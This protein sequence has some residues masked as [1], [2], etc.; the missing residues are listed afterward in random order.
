MSKFEIYS[1]ILCIIVFIML[2]GV[3]SYL[4]TFIVKLGLKHIRAGLDDEDILKEFNSDCTVKQSRFSKVFNGIVNFTLC[5]VI[6]AIFLSSF[7]IAC[8][9][10]VYTENVPTYRVVL[11]SSMENKN[12]E[13]EYLFEN[14]LN[15][16]L[17][18]F[19]LITT[20]KI[21]KEE[22][23]K[24]YDIVV[25][26]VDGVLIVHRIVGI[27]E[28]NQYHP[29]E[30]H[31]LLQGDAVGSPD[32]F[33]VLY[34]QMKGIYKGQKIPFVG[35][36]ILFMQSPAGWICLFLIIV[37]IIVTP[38]LEKK[39]LN[40]R[41]KRFLLVY[42]QSQVLVSEKF[43]EE[44]SITENVDNV[45]ASTQN[46]TNNAYI[47]EEIIEFNDSRFSN[48]KPSKTFI[49]K[50][51][52]SSEQ[53]KNRYAQIIKTL[54]RIENVRVIEGKSQ[55]S[56]K[57]KSICIARLLFKG[58]TLNV[59]LGLNPK[60]YE[61]SKYVFTDLSSKVKHK[62]YPTCLK[63]TSDRQTRWACELIL[64]LANDKGLKILEVPTTP[65]KQ[66]SPFAHLKSKRKT[67]KQK[68]KLSPI[69]K[70]R[71]NNLKTYLEKIKGIK[72][73]EGKYQTTFKVKN[74]SLIK[75]AIKGKMLNAYLGLSPIDYENSKYI[76]TDVSKIKKFAN[77]P[78][79]VKVSSDRQQRWVK[80][81]LVDKINKEGLTIIE[82]PIII[83]NKPNFARL[84]RKKT[85]SFKQKLK[86]SPIAK[87]RFIEIKKAFNDIP[88]VRVI[89]GK[90][91]VTYKLK[92]LCIAKFLIKGKTLNVYLNL[93]PVD[94]ENTKYIFTDVS[95]VKKYINYPMRVKVSSNRQVKWVKELIFKI[96]NKGDK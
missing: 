14:N 93:K 11:T 26:E 66:V 48:F 86:L 46:D 41:K 85:R 7:Y 6:G 25:Y 75:F 64:E 70:E 35:S 9:Q 28:P 62:N 77:Y 52:I 50:L 12:E 63:L 49:E 81:L 74:V 5:L 54:S 20:Y 15:N 2:V 91:N 4:L 88:N 43:I 56:Y 90:N 37:A 84:K 33:P 55:H 95:N 78:M 34:S 8:T 18:A 92:S 16:Q 19:D 40:E 58:K 39:L 24:L 38:I 60:N 29:N 3:F 68:L 69:A 53:M 76:F 82:E 96:V 73:L 67:F 59:C 31:F 17:S 89:E 47:S 83:D 42:P 71:F 45:I 65:V 13:N 30:R 79:R 87:E 80:E 51:Q 23:L 57:S 22:D 10:N 36:F 94:F 32:R 1:L 61:N 21:P 72:I 44:I 27:E